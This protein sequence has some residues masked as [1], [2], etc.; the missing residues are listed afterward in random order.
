MVKLGVNVD[1]VA[2]LRQARR[3]SDPDPVVA[4]AI[5]EKVG[6]HSI[7]AHLREDR[8]HIQDKDILVLRKTV[9]T[10]FNLEMSIHPSIVD[11]ACAIKPDQATLVPERRQEITT[12]GGLDV[13]RYFAKLKKVCGQ[14]SSRGIVVSMFIDPDKKQIDAVK[15][16]GVAM[17]ELHTG[18]YARAFAVRRGQ[19]ELEKLISMT[20]YARKSG[21]TVNAGHGLNYANT[22]AVARIPGMEELNIGHAIMSRAMFVGLKQAVKEM[23]ACI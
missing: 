5:C 4:A 2:T 13:V 20:K 12:E 11:V 16:L 3:E 21:I 6:A 7:V 10:C 19:K 1:H 9:K 14:L 18:A 23:L 8:R 15:D 22:R 17:I